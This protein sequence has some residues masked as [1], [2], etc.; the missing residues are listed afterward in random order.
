MFSSGSLIIHMCENPLIIH[1]SYFKILPLT[2]LSINNSNRVV[3]HIHIFL[4]SL[5]VTIFPFSSICDIIYTSLR[6]LLLVTM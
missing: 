4:T 5:N 1:L 3:T 2:I 6:L